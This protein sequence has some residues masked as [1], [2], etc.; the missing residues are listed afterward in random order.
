MHL[1]ASTMAAT[2][3]FPT[4]YRR[5]APMDGLE[6]STWLL[7]RP[8][9]HSVRGGRPRKRVLANKG[10]HELYSV[11]A[12]PF[13]TFI[14]PGI[15]ISPLPHLQT[16]LPCLAIAHLPPCPHGLSSCSLQS[17]NNW[18]PA[19][20]ADLGSWVP[21]LTRPSWLLSPVRSTASSRSTSNRRPVNKILQTDLE[22]VLGLRTST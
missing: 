5:T 17:L 4:G 21:I 9:V 1:G 10:S 2:P 11:T 7:L 8:R 14:F 3:A 6:G 12:C 22:G 13:C 19:S 20:S 16:H 18:L 15:P